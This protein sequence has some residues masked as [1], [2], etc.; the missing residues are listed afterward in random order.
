MLQAF[1]RSTEDRRDVEDRRIG[2][3]RRNSGVESSLSKENYSRKQSVLCV[4]GRRVRENKSYR[5][6]NVLSKDTVCWKCVDC[7]EW[8]Y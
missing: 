6:T 5:S 2:I 7:L 3:L 8:M 1:A 4:R